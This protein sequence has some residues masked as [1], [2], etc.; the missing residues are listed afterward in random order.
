[1]LEKLIR[2]EAYLASIYEQFP[3]QL[4]A[5]FGPHLVDLRR[6]LLPTADAERLVA[7]TTLGSQSVH[8]EYTS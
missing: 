7:I 6:C 2:N 4:E 1:V 3:A 5:I 8:K